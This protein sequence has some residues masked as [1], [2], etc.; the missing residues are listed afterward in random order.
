MGA[1]QLAC[2]SAALLL[3]IFIFS[4]SVYRAATQPIAHDE[5]L[6][7]TW[8]LDGGV[9]SA[10]QFNST[11]HVLFTLLAKPCVKLLGVTEFTLRLPALVGAAFYLIGAYLL[12][13]K[14]FG[15]KLLMLASVAL[16]CLHPTTMD[17]MAAARGYSLGLGFLICGMYFA[18]DL[19]GRSE[20]DFEDKGFRRECGT[21]SILLAL[22]VTANVTNAIPL[23]SLT[24]SL[25][26][27]L[28]AYF[29]W[30]LSVRTFAWIFLVPGAA[31]GL[32]IF[33][34]FLIQ[35]RPAQFAMGL[36]SASD[37]LRDIFNSS[38]LYKWTGDIYSVSLGALPLSPGSFL[39]SVS[40]LGVYV[41]LPLLFGF[42][43][44]GLVFLSRRDPP[45]SAGR[46]NTLLFAGSAMGAV[47]L[48]WI[49]H[50]TIQM[51]YPVARTSLY[52]VPLFTVAAILVAR[53]L[54]SSFVGGWLKIV[55]ILIAGAVIADYTASLNTK[56]FRYN[57]YDVISR[58]LFRT[59]YADAQSR[60]LANVRIGGTWWYQPEIDF[61]TRRYHATTI[62]PYDTVD[63][64]YWWN[65]PNALAP[66]KY[67]YFVFTQLN[68]PFLSGPRIRSIFHNATF[69]VA[70]E[71]HEK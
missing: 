55:C 29:N 24:V 46:A 33:W 34:P 3:L 17:F 37:S 52:L 6:E 61:Y 41:M 27:V 56:Y 28:R 12:S 22:S 36:H 71:A 59:I 68:D 44:C 51:N 60:N 9:L 21:V 7:Y 30:K 48:N 65:T 31:V 38:F 26:L 40:D 5:A 43:S 47:V 53:E 49:L 16:L 50:A 63:R 25:F 20:S 4:L 2:R 45:I 11:N 57:Q 58:D 62:A 1:L 35:A 42:I 19:L 64:S 67:D 15:E 14:L 54:S 39:K 10:L 70:V 13:S 32:S 8:F 18:A 66:E 23:A 69:G